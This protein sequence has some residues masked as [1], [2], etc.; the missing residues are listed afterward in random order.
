MEIRSRKEWVT[1]HLN[2]VLPDVERPY[3]Y[4]YDPGPGHPAT[5]CRYE[6]VACAVLDARSVPRQGRFSATGFTL[7]EAGSAVDDFY[8]ADQVTQRYYREV[9]DLAL[10]LTGGRDAVVFDHLLREREKGRPALGFGRHG[11]GSRPAAVGRVH[12]DYSDA[13]GMRRLRMVKPLADAATPFLILNFWRPVLYPA[14]DTPLAVCAGD[15]VGPADWMA[16]EVIYPT[17]R[18]EI[19]LSR[20]SPHHRWYYY[21]EMGTDEVLVFKTYDSRADEPARMVPHC[22]FDDPSTPPDAPL[23]RSIEVRCLVTLA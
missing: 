4:M 7:C 9:E 8:D 19:Y 15:T 11:D 3:V 17:R 10:Q 6:S 20:Y 16:A 23:R 1:G 12:N 21:P 22:A 5:N 2:Y 18:G 14:I 13:A